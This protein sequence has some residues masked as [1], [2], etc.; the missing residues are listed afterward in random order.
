MNP[1]YQKRRR[2]EDR[3]ESFYHPSHSA[4]FG[5]PT[6][7]SHFKI[8]CVNFFTLSTIKLFYRRSQALDGSTVDRV[9]FRGKDE[10]DSLRRSM[11]FF[12]CPLN[13]YHSNLQQLG[14]QLSDDR[15]VLLGICTI[16]ASSLS[17]HGLFWW[18]HIVHSCRLSIDKIPTRP[19]IPLTI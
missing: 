1:V 17:W 13:Y 16:T 15:W 3:E 9:S 6:A 14:F 18:Q 2:N 10:T 5:A 7:R 19:P 12:I 8:S 4:K 11:Q